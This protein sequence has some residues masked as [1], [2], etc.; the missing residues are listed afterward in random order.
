MLY[1]MQILL[2]RCNVPYASSGEE[3]QESLS[4]TAFIAVLGRVVCL[5]FTSVCK[6]KWL[7]SRSDT[8]RDEVAVQV[9]RPYA[10]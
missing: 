10:R 5:R 7:F 9:F 6:I 4:S 8:L 1:K 2:L 3:Q